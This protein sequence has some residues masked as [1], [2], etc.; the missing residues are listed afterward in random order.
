MKNPTEEETRASRLSES[1]SVT[2]WE[3]VG[4]VL[5]GRKCCNLWAIYTKTTLEDDV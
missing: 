2:E 4:S 3:R 1:V 5:N